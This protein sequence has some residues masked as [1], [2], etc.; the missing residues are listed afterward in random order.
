MYTQKLPT[1]IP[2]TRVA[3]LKLRSAEFDYSNH[4]CIFGTTPFGFCYGGFSST[5]DYVSGN[6]VQ[7]SLND[8]CYLGYDQPPKRNPFLSGR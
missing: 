8:F 1:Y 5:A 4:T 3:V 7:L 2:E 6:E